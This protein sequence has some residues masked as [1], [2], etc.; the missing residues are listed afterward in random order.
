MTIE[1][2]EQELLGR[3]GSPLGRVKVGAVEPKGVDSTFAI[4]ANSVMRAVLRPSRKLVTSSTTLRF[5]RTPS[6]V[7]VVDNIAA[8]VVA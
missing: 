3:A 4:G 2:T 7:L 5:R 1:H 6:I 8:P